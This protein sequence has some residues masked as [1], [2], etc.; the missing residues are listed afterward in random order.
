[1]QTI[2]PGSTQ[3]SAE[4]LRR[5]LP[6]QTQ[7]RIVIISAVIGGI[8]LGLWQAVAW[9]VERRT[10]QTPAI[11]APGTFRP[12]EEQWSSL[13]VATVRALNFRSGQTTDGKIAFNDDKTTPVFSPY[14]GRVTKLLA[15]AGDVVEP[16]TP[17]LAI[18]ASEFVQGQNDLIAALA[19]LKTAQAQFSFAQANEQRQE[20]LYE[21]KGGSFKDWRQSQVDLANAEGGLRTAQIAL[22]AVRNR[23]RIL[24]MSEQEVAAFEAAPEGQQMNGEA[25]V[26]AP[27]GGVVTQRQVALGQYINSAAGGAS[28]PVF[29]I[30]DLSTVW[31]VANVR[32]TDAP[33][34]RVG[35]PV[36]VQV[37]AFPGRIFSAK[38]IYVA[39]MLDPNTHRLVVR[40]ELP[41]P[42]GALK[43]EMF[44]SFQI[45]SSGES[46]S[47]AVPAE[48]IVYEGD[49]ARVWVVG[50][51][52]TV[53]LRNIKVGH[54][55]DGMVE[56][57]SGITV[58]ETV[59]SSGSLFIDRAAK[60]Q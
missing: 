24:G 39:S 19:T 51:D 7:I 27:I 58:G 38:L 49:T 36:E 42:D 37:L 3:L 45:I 8:A 10:G 14:T 60:A 5:A 56:A 15:K 52:R 34:M 43:P 20:Q 41:N 40:A 25:I 57:L 22:G 59:V 54:S 23:L 29:T 2:K 16:G 30:G 4:H 12:T 44:A 1:M 11:T 6:R 48:A 50:K 35:D 32:E 55:Q 46:Q 18:E 13:K 33:L 28:T 9:L 31:L 53:G 21:A 17:L 26:R 47:P